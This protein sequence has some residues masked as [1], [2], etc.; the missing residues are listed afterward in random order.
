MLH[1]FLTA[2][3]AALISDCRARAA[4][5]F[6]SPMSDESI[7]HGVPL[8]LQQLVESLRE[9][10]PERPTD[11]A[12]P[13]PAPRAAA[14]GRGAARH[15]AELLLQGCSIDQVVRNYG[16][17]CQSI[18]T[19]AIT[20][21]APISIDEFRTLNRCLDDAIAD[22]V[23]AFKSDR[24]A[25]TQARAEILCDSLNEFADEHQRLVELAIQAYSAIR[26]GTVGAAGSTGTMLEQTLLGL[27]HL[28]A[29]NL[30][31]IRLASAMT[32]VGQ[33]KARRTDG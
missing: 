10:A 24:Q 22:A 14:I 19:L 6:A 8:F 27:R 13:R 21:Q 16:D 18:T 11:G 28:A 31:A 7:A 17:V 12:E 2:H 29:R 9:E 15:G 23:T 5:R 33:Q 1:E 3:R 4:A 25:Q 32:T 26:S 20:L 30:P